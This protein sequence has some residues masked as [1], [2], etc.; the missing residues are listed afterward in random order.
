MAW[1][2]CEVA[3]ISH[4][5]ILFVPNL[6]ISFYYIYIKKSLDFWENWKCHLFNSN[7]AL[8]LV[9]TKLTKYKR[10]LTTFEPVLSVF[11]KQSK[12]NPFVREEVK[13]KEK[14][15]HQAV[16]KQHP[17]QWYAWIR[18]WY[19]FKPIALRFIGF[20]NPF[21]SKKM[22]INLFI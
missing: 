13:I 19:H 6:A 2:Y 9:S 1:C 3:S 21:S 20:L 4:C 10:D 11:Y 17:P 12:G 14:I 8:T 16:L 18:F 22:W 15:K 5:L 7:S